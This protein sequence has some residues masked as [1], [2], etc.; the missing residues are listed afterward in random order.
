MSTPRSVP[1]AVLAAL[2]NLDDPLRR[3]L[4]EYVSESEAPV[5]REQAAAA[6][7]VGRTLAAYHLDKLADAELLTVSYQRPAGRGGPGAGRPAKLYTR[8]A[9][10]LSV[11][12]PPRDYELLARLLV[13]SVEQDASGA[14]RAAVNEAA[15]DAGKR[16]AAATGGDLL[17]AL[18]GC[19]YLP[20]VD[21]DGRVDLRNCPFHRVARDHLD[22]VCGLNLRL[23]EGV[24][25][26]STQ[27]DARAELA[28]GPGRCC[29]VVHYVASGQEVSAK[30]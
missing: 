29:V 14:V 15:V 9:T 1:P 8:A 16:A 5:S 30:P 6:V 28:P 20:Q 21:A 27:R 11:S 19:G 17:E 24:I 18:R 13:S 10:E 22:V 12:V 23:V 26:G 4:Y 3:R 25:A 7:D 2:S